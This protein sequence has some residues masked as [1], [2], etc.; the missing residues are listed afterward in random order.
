ML[1]E[2]NIVVTGIGVISPIGNGYKRFAHNLLQNVD[3][4][5]PLQEL[6]TTNF[7][8][9]HGCEIAPFDPQQYGI[10]P[11]WE[12]DECS[13]MAIC[14]TLEA[15]TD[16]GLSN[17]IQRNP[18]TVA[19]A[20]SIL[21]GGLSA[22]DEY[23]VAKYHDDPVDTR[24][25]LRTPSRIAQ[26]VASYFGFH[27]P[28]IVPSTACAASINSVAL[29]AD[30]LRLGE[31]DIVVAGG[32][33]PITRITYIGFN[34]LQAVS[35]D[36]CKPFDEHRNGIA[37]GA[38]SVIFTLEREADARARGAKIYA[39]VC[40]YGLANDAHHITAP[41]PDGRAL[42]ATITEALQQA[43][44]APD[45]VDYICAHGTGTPYNDLAE[46]KAIQAVF[47]D[48]APTIPI[49][50]IKSALGHT[51]GTAG[52]MNILACIVA[53]QEQRVPGTVHLEQKLSEFADWNLP[54]RSQPTDVRVA[55]TNALAFAGH[56]ASMILAR[57]SDA[58][59]E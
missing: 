20:I 45:D 12:G 26:N 39:R 56:T 49:S 42:R 28:V 13:L 46:L 27:G 4:I 53:L 3:S 55:L 47:G 16:A 58:S 32:A 33:D 37:I 29:G 18:Y 43:G 41:H 23:A 44:Y 22:F 7:R 2:Q 21:T 9:T 24:I 8:T 15:I 25:T 36:T 50:S 54:N 14:A 5:G 38:G 40:S 17:T 11:N 6:D 10:T 48:A 57:P 31:A 1:T 34:L 51:M 59:D 52:A 19:T 30:L 35:H